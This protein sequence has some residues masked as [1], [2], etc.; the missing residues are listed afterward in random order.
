MVLTA[1]PSR[2]R[3]GK[4]APDPEPAPE[5]YFQ[6]LKGSSDVQPDDVIAFQPGLEPDMPA[7]RGAPPAGVV[8]LPPKGRERLRRCRVLERVGR[9]GRTRLPQLTG[10]RIDEHDLEAR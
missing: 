7:V 3:P 10:G 4:L 1:T 2:H 6:T 9:H 8:A 5:N